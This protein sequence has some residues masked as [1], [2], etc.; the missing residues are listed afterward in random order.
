MEAEFHFFENSCFRTKEW[1]FR[2]QLDEL[3][4]W[5]WRWDQPSENWWCN[6]R[7]NRKVEG[8]RH[9]VKSRSLCLYLVEAQPAWRHLFDR[10]RSRGYNFN[11]QTSHTILITMCETNQNMYI[12]PARF[13]TPCRPANVSQLRT[14]D[15]YS[16]WYFPR[17]YTI[18]IGYKATPHGQNNAI[19]LTHL[20]IVTSVL[21]GVHSAGE[22][23]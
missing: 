19:L 4:L 9:S 8:C 7:T 5:L 10:T 13:T 18:C 1:W 11:T 14:N 21:S 15:T 6:W 12:P 2:C 3:L 20:F 17:M 23:Q 16:N 22:S